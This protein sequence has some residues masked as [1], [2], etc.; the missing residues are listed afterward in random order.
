MHRPF[1]CSGT[2]RPGGRP[3]SRGC[4]L[5]GR[6]TFW[7]RSSALELILGLND[8]EPRVREQSARLAEPRIA[9]DA[10]LLAV[11]LTLADDS[12]PMV[13]FQTALTL[14]EASGDPRTPDGTGPDRRA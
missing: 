1:R 2:S 6:S 12:D 4:T 3:R 14:G 10:E 7:D 11:V 8:P 9:R 13:R 5:S